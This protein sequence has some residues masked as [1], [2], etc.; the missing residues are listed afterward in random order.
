MP[1]MA[2][3]HHGI[4]FRE[5]LATWARIGLESFGGPAGQ[6]AVMHRVL[7]EEKRWIS[8][9]R[10][11][12]ALNYCMLLPG[13][14]AMQLGVYVGWL[15]HRTLGGLVAGILFVLPGALAILGLSIV[16]A[17]WH[18]VAFVEGLFFGLK[19]AVLA[20]VIEAV[21]RIAR[22]ALGNATLT[23]LAAATFVALFFFD[24]PFPVVVVGAAAVGLLGGRVAPERFESRGTH[25]PAGAGAA[26]VDAMLDEAVPEHARASLRG[27][28]RVA[29]VWMALWW[30]PL[31]LLLA[32][33]GVRDTWP[34]R[35]RSW[36]SS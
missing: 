14:E 35:P 24:V 25:A 16:Y 29:A 23:A 12:H 30:T 4:P 27:S 32:V 17:T 8:E 20:V 11:L 5:A 36:A 19:P 33:R 10:F 2:A 18:H 3:P 7:V 28:L 31:L 6:I 9:Q 34:S 21:L 26:A 22:R 15:L 13:P 1:G